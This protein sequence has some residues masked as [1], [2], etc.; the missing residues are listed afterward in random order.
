[1]DVFAL[2][3]RVV[4]DYRDYIGSFVRIRDEQ[5]DQFVRRKFEEGALWPDAILQLNPAY[6]AGQSLD[7]LAAGGMI[8]RATADFFRGRDG[9]YLTLYKHQE[10]AIQI[11]RRWEPY[12]V[13]TGNGVW[14]EPHV[15][16]SHRGPCPPD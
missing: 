3:D 15:P 11:A 8:L 5:I 1:M 9:R 13:T 2:R 14:Q 16:H 12:V 6:A 10:E 7:Q 4:K